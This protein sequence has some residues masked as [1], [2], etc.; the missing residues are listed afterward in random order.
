MVEKKLGYSYGV[1][2]FGARGK[3]YPLTK[4][5]ADHNHDRIKTVDRGEVGNEVD[6]EVLEGARA[7]KGK[8]SDGWDHSMS[9]DFV[10]LANCTSGNK[11][12][13]VGGE[14]RPLVIL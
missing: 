2:G 8:G 4:A 10:C 7:L 11:F 5:M 12:P 3:N 1:H 14:A 6:G 9:E 13:G